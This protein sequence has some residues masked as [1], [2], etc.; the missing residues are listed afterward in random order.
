MDQSGN[1]SLHLAIWEGHESVVGALVE[2]G[3]DIPT[4]DNNDHESVIRA[5]KYWG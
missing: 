2:L 5:L 3:A 4:K 1:T